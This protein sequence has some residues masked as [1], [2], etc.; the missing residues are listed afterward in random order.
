MPDQPNQDH[1]NRFRLTAQGNQDPN[2]FRLTEEEWQMAVKGAKEGLEFLARQ[3]KR[4]PQTPEQA[5]LRR[6]A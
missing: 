6:L 4:E 2:R 1:P 5:A 3:P